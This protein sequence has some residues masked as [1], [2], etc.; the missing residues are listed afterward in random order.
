M[1]CSPGRAGRRLPL[2]VVRHCL[3]CGIQKI[4]D[5][6]LFW[7]GP[8]RNSG[9]ELHGNGFREIR[10]QDTNTLRIRRSWMALY[11]QELIA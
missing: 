6:T 7:T 11:G 5:G 4:K 8:V 2:G 10:A 3:V 9:F 1:I